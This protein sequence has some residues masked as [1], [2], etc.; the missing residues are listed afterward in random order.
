MLSAW[1]LLNLFCA[2]GLEFCAYPAFFQDLQYRRLKVARLHVTK[3]QGFKATRSINE[4]RGQKSAVRLST[5]FRF[6]TS[7]FIARCTQY[8]VP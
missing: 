4:V 7:D 8:P 3:S 6:Q 5:D 1:S 2:L